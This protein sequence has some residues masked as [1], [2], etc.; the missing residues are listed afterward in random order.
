MSNGNGHGAAWGLALVGGVASAASP[1][2]LPALLEDIGARI[3]A[4]LVT[5]AAIALA[6]WAWRRL[7]KTPER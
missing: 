3:V 2:T 1:V 6:S 4:G 7:R 5:T